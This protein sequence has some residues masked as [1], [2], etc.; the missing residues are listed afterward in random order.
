MY[1]NEFLFFFYIELQKIVSVKLQF[2]LIIKDISNIK[3][4]NTPKHNI[5]QNKFM[6]YIWWPANIHCVQLD[7]MMEAQSRLVN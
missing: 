3:H 4:L 5:Y 1:V 7:E 2:S 6:E